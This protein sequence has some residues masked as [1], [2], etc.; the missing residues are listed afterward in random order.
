V[1]QLIEAYPDDLRVAVCMLPLEFHKRAEPSARAALAAHVQG[2]FWEYNDRLFLDNRELEDSHLEEHARALGLDVEQW[3]RDFASSRIREHVAHQATLAAALGVRGTPN[4]FINGE[5]VRGAKPL[6]E[7][8]K[9]IDRK[10]IKARK[11]EASGTPAASLHAALTT[12]AVEG[13]YRK[14]VIDGAKPVR[15][16]PPPPKKPLVA[17][18]VELPVG[19]SPRKGTGDK[20]IIT[21]FSDFQ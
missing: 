19:D 10:L 1:N 16:P 5:N 14:Y 6:E 3:K 18:V 2:K 21:E 9:L 4:I 12:S 15:P 20:I 7:F 13:K 11:L 8:R 17:E